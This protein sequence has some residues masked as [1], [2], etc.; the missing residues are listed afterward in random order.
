MITKRFCRN[1][2]GSG[3]RLHFKDIDYESLHSVV[4]R[5]KGCIVDL[6][7]MI[8]YFFI[9]EPD[10]VESNSPINSVRLASVPYKMFDKQ[11]V[12]TVLVLSRVC[13]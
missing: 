9:A 6:I 11:M 2:L 10:K 7:S 3:Y 8:A 13:V 5:F 4:V 1:Q 12:S